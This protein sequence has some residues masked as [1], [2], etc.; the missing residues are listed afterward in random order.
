MTSVGERNFLP[1]PASPRNNYARPF[2]GLS[3]NELPFA[4]QFVYIDLT[5]LEKFLVLLGRE[6]FLSVALLADEEHEFF[7]DGYSLLDLL[8]NVLSPMLAPRIERW[9]HFDQSD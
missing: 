8:M 7:H 6:R 1:C 4:F 2:D 5:A 9:H 3:R